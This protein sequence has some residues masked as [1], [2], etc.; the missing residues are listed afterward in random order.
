[1]NNVKINY[2]GELSINPFDLNFDIHLG[3]YKISKLFSINPILIEFIKSGLLFNENISVNTFLTVKS[4]HKNEIFH[5]AEINFN[6]I[7]GKID[8]DNTKLE[9]DDIGLMQVSNSNLFFKNNELVFNGDI[10]IDI[11]NSENLFSLLN[12]NKFAR[13][14]LQTI[15]IN[16]DYNFLSNK[17]KFNNLKINNLDVDDQLLTIIDGFNDNEQNNYNKSRRLLNQ[18]FNAYSG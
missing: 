16:L 6:I 12:T 18:L 14:D 5:K 13:K 2:T 4:N 8:F 7:N 11:R 1:M 17:I 15:L 9:N 3:N 10:S